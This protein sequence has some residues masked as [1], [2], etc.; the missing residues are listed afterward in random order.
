MMAPL[1]RRTWNPRGATPL[2]RHC[3][4]THRKSSVIGAL[5]VAPDR[6]DVRLYFRLHPNANINAERV[7]DFL[8]QL[9]AEIDA[10]LVLIWDRLNAH[11]A[12]LVQDFLAAHRQIATEFFPPYAPELNPME[13]VW[14]YL[15]L[16]PLANLAFFDLEQLTTTARR[17][18]RSLQRKPDLLRSFLRHS[19]LSLR[20][21]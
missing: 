8:R 15:K 20:L 10:P 16:N 14:S 2:L 13:Y 3:G 9:L 1:L 4:G 11:R 7:V 12:Y 19:P 6:S 21:G 18:T 5:C 17:H